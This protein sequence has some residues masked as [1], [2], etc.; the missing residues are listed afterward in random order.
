MMLETSK[1]T[2]LRRVA[3]LRHL[4]SAD[5]EDLAS[6][7]TEMTIAEGDVVR[8][9]DSACT[10]VVVIVDGCA[11]LYRDGKQIGDL[12]P[13]ELVA[14]EAPLDLMTCGADVVATTAMRVLVL[15]RDVVRSTLGDGGVAAAFVHTALAR[16]RA[17][18]S[19]G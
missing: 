9:P 17:N 5:L 10:N 13:G 4:A 12:G 18:R 7:A 8:R 1:A 14:G 15:P 11:G 16:L 19:G 6:R 2:V 3:G